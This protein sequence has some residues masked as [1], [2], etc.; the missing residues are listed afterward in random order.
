MASATALYM[1]IQEAI[2]IRQCLID[3][4]HP[5]PPTVLEADYQTAT[6]ILNGIIKQ[7]QPKAID[8]YFYLLK[9]CQEQGQF[10]INWV[11]DKYNLADYHTK[12]HPGCHHCQV[13][14]IYLHEG[15]TSPTVY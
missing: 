1:T 9:D 3:L 12:H 8:I 6:G 2:P 5:Q 11:P 4:G 7:K 15:E 10:N 14:P 13:H